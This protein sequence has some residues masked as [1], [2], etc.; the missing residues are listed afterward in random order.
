MTRPV[1]TRPPPCS[2]AL[3][4][5]AAAVL[6]ALRK[7]EVCGPNMVAFLIG[8]SACKLFCDHVLPYSPNYRAPNDIDVVVCTH[9]A[10]EEVKEQ[11]AAAQENIHLVPS[12]T[13][14]MNYRVLRYGSK[15]TVGPNGGY[16]K[17]IK[18]DVLVATRT[19]G[20][21]S[22]PA[23]R[24]YWIAGRWP[25]APLEFLILLRLQGWDDHKHSPL[26]HH[27]EKMM[28]DVGDLA[29][30]LVPFVLKAWD[31]LSEGGTSLW[32]EAKSYLADEFIA[33]SHVRAEAF[34]RD[35]PWAR[36]DWERLG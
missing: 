29:G 27:R 5:A 30:H 6:D 36:S 35:H 32:A 26:E 1:R 3:W 13:P 2:D 15:G 14:G 11:L 4:E 7:P 23:H 10:Q 33:K 31:G 21:P 17:L 16:S 28:T 24:V 9:L 22:I 25:V 34:V 20:I 12:K 18:I 8:S 19:L